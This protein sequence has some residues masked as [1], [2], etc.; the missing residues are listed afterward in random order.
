[1]TMQ[2]EDAEQIISNVAV[3]NMAGQEVYRSENLDVRYFP[4][5]VAQLPEGMYIAQAMTE[6]GVI[7]KKFQVVR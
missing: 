6:A 1:M 2:F 7:S 3:I 5:P 4:I